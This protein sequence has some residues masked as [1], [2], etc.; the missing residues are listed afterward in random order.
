[1]YL[2]SFYVTVEPIS[3]NIPTQTAIANATNI[4]SDAFGHKQQPALLKNSLKTSEFKKRG[5]FTRNPEVGSSQ[6]GLSV[7]LLLT[8]CCSDKLSQT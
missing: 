6:G 1:M 5:H 7:R 4:I 8:S 3:Y 2:N